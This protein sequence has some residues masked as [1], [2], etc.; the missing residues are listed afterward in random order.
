MRLQH[1]EATIFEILDLEIATQ[2]PLRP[3][4]TFYLNQQEYDYFT[5]F[6][7][8]H[9]SGVDYGDNEGWKYCYR[10]IPVKKDLA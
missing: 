10:N 6:Y 4:E 5:E 1:R 9:K 7:S 2:D 8:G 3:I